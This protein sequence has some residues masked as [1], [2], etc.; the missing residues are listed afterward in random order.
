MGQSR[1]VCHVQRHVCLM[2]DYGNAGS[3]SWTVITAD[4]L[5][6]DTPRPRAD[7]QRQAFDHCASQRVSS[8][9]RA[10]PRSIRSVKLEGGRLCDRR[11]DQRPA[12][13][14]D[15]GPTLTRAAIEGSTGIGRFP[16]TVIGGHG[17]IVAIAPGAH[18]PR[19]RHVARR[20]DCGS[21]WT[22]LR[23]CP[24]VDLRITAV[25]KYTLV[26]R[27]SLLRGAGGCH[28]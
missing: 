21:S 9:R 15:H 24:W 8:T 19:S 28:G 20:T 12:F 5:F 13:A 11:P 7:G 27:K 6:S 14:L 18:K 16:S 4:G 3:R 17:S 26:E 23:A 25:A 2:R 1:Q 10:R 22:L